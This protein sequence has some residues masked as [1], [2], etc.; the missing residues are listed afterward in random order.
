MGDHDSY[1]DLIMHKRQ[2]RHQWTG[3]CSGKARHPGI[4]ECLSTAVW[5]R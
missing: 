5:R 1:S 2:E 3:D 4:W